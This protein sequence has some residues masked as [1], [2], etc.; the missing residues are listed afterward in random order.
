[1]FRFRLN[2]FNWEYYVDDVVTTYYIKSG[3]RKCQF[4]P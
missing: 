2:I 4:V 1:M 3:D